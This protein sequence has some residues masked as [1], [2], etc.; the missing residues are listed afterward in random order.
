MN[1]H[2]SFIYS[3]IIYILVGAIACSAEQAPAK[4]P[5]SAVQ[6]INF[7]SFQVESIANREYAYALNKNLMEKGY[8]AYVEEALTIQAK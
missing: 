6:K 5:R 3:A 4:A 1:N 2:L 7:Y 8:P